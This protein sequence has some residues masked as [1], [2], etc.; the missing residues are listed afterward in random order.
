MALSR[1]TTYKW[2]S[3]RDNY[4]A[5]QIYRSKNLIKI[6]KYINCKV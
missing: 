5:I 4:Q 2:E 1:E 6:K 3:S